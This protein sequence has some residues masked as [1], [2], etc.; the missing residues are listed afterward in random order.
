MQLSEQDESSPK[1][2][3]TYEDWLTAQ[4]R[5]IDLKIQEGVV[6]YPTWDLSANKMVHLEHCFGNRNTYVCLEQT[7]SN[8]I[9]N[10]II[11]LK[12]NQSEWGD[13]IAISEHV[14]NFVHAVENAGSSNPVSPSDIFG[15]H[16]I[17]KTCGWLSSTVALTDQ[18]HLTFRWKEGDNSMFN[19]DIRRGYMKLVPGKGVCWVGTQQG[20][21]LGGNILKLF[22]GHIINKVTNGIRMW[23][24]MNITGCHLQESLLSTYVGKPS[25][26]GQ[27]FQI[28]HDAMEDA[29]FPTD[30]DTSS[31]PENFEDFVMHTSL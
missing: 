30:M 4:L 28:R 1:K 9:F 22:M 29:D 10:R 14:R 24:E 18:I 2:L 7:Q 26:K 15:N 16:R 19:M 13:F 6:Q 12:L 27:L 11:K 3:K 20:I 8:P 21:T 23:E 31:P 25:R 17:E 5:Q